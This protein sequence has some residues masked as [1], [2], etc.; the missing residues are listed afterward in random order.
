MDDIDLETCIIPKPLM[1]DGTDMDEFLK[2]H[3]IGY[4]T[5]MHEPKPLSEKEKRIQEVLMK[6][7]EAGEPLW[8]PEDPCDPD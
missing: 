7:L 5:I 2:R 6:Q 3:G 8:C 4:T 1:Y